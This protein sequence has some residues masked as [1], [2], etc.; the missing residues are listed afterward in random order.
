MKTSQHVIILITTH[1]MCHVLPSKGLKCCTFHGHCKLVKEFILRHFNIKKLKFIGVYK[2]KNYKSKMCL[3][4][5]FYM[6]Q[7]RK[8]KDTFWAAEFKFG[9]VE[10][11]YIDRNTYSARLSL[12]LALKSIYNILKM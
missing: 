4:F 9:I 1:L 3:K 2:C 6:D 11:K 8:L 5:Y 10:F 12:C 7:F